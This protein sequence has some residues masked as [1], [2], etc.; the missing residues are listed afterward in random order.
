MAIPPKLKHINVK[1]HHVRDLL[2]TDAYTIKY[3]PSAENTADLFTKG[4]TK[5]PFDNHCKTL[6]LT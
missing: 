4:L 3:V 6:G 1:L 2:K 5:I